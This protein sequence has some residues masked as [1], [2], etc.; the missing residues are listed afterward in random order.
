M[1][2]LNIF[3]N[4]AVKLTVVSPKEV[5]L[6]AALGGAGALLFLFVFPKGSISTLMHVLRVPGPGSGIALVVGP[7]LV[8]VVLVSSLLSPAKGGALIASMAFAVSYTLVVR[9]FGIA[10]DPKG[11]FG[12]ASFVAAIALFGLAAETVMA[13]SGALSQVWQ[14]VLTGALANTVLLVF[15]WLV[16]FP[17]TVGWVKWKDI[18]LLTGACL[19]CG[20]VTG[21][22]AW[23]VSAPLARAVKEKE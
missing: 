8:L 2:A 19:V 3:E 6:G 22:V 7:F 11:A 5:A 18:P 14:C 23:R 13:L 12:S 21:F 10:T 9:L 1:G 17:R 4:R 16:I 20:L 15:Y